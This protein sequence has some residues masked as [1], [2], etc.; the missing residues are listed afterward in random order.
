MADKKG[1]IVIGSGGQARVVISTCR[2]AGIPLEA[3]YDDDPTRWGKDLMGVPIY[4]PVDE[5]L[6]R[7][8]YPVIV[9][10]GDARTRR[11]LTQRLD[12]NWGT[13][14]HPHSFVDP[15]A[16]LGPGTVV[17]S[18]AVVQPETQIGAHAIIN[19]SATVDH[20]C[21]LEDYVQV[22]P[23]AN[24]CGN[25]SVGAGTF[26]GAN[27]VVLENLKLGQ[28]AIVGAGAVVIRDL[29]DQVVAVGCPAQVIKTLEIVD[30]STE[31]K[32]SKVRQAAETVIQRVL[33][34]SG[35]EVKPIS[36]DDTLS[37]VLHLD[38]L[39]LA[40]TV[41]GLEQELGVDPF[42]DGASPVQTFGQLVAVYEKA[43]EEQ[44]A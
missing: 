35:R 27:A 5:I 41:V 23:G 40:V 24:L 44:S 22:A 1:I 20:N 36:D 43:C 32:R 7:S 19:T 11:L 28:W 42:R 39:D 8:D 9:G 29:P 30:E 38:S 3:V 26:V 4:G 16:Q 2:A 21:I 34:E 33:S 12:L 13:V 25:V 37:D 17:F 18:G 10:V 15:S 14:V 6:R 31:K